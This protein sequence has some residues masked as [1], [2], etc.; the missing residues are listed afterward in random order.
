ML[1]YVEIDSPSS[2]LKKNEKNSHGTAGG[3][4]LQ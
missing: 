4:N 3:I 2:E 1:R